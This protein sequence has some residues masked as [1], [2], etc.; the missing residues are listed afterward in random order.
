LVDGAEI[1]FQ[2]ADAAEVRLL[3]GIRAY[4]LHGRLRV[5]RPDVVEHQPADAPAQ[6]AGGEAN[7]ERSTHRSAQPVKGTEVELIG[8]RLG[9]ARVERQAVFALRLGAPFG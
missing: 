7:A 4:A 3:A 5:L 1:F 2:F 8:Q 6:S 9:D